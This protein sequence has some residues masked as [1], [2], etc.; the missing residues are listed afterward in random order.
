MIAVDMDGIVSN[1][2]LGFSKVVREL[3]AGAAPLVTNYDDIT[4]WEWL[5]WYWKGRF[6]A[7]LNEQA[8]DEINRSFD[9]WQGLEPLFPEQMDE[10]R[11]MNARREVV[12][13]TRREGKDAFWQTMDWLD[14]YGIK[15]ALLIRVHGGEEKH[16]L[17]KM[18]GINT[19]ID[20]APKTMKLCRDAG[21][22]VVTI[23]WPYNESIT[24]VSR[25]TDLTGALL[26]AKIEGGH[27]AQHKMSL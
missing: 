17:C 25:A 22:H 11:A 27:L 5:P 19:I 3:T 21:M 13:M 18:L 2:S 9:F 15:E 24:G 12:F 8:W 23:T 6:S 20:D 4:E 14:K 16:V 10:L 7:K 26:A 1:F